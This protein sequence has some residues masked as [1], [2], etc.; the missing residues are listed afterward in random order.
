LVFN[1]LP[2]NDP[3]EDTMLMIVCDACKKAVSG[4]QKET[5]VV[6]VLDK[7]LC[8]KCEAALRD[9]VS[10]EMLKQKVYRLADYRDRYITTMK[11]MCR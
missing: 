10:E 7:A 4:D 6:Y 11:K 5:G 3:L 1:N 2:Y 9:S 8:R